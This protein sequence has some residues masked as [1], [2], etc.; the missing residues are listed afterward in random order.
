[1][2]FAPIIFWFTHMNVL[3]RIPRSA[4]TQ[5]LLQVLCGIF[6]SLGSGAFHATLWYEL[7]LWDELGIYCLVLV[8]GSTS[9]NTV[10]KTPIRILGS[11]VILTIL[12]TLGDR[13][14]LVHQSF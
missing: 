7:Q 11:L 6:L 1:M 10:F 4:Q 8:C 3:N 14:G 5:L 9:G 13:H 2:L 12:L